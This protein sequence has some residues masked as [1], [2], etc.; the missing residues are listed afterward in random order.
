MVA[1]GEDGVGVG[2][3]VDDFDLERLYFIWPN[4]NGATNNPAQI[5]IMTRVM[6]R[7][8]CDLIMKSKAIL[9]RHSRSENNKICAR[10]FSIHVGH[11]FWPA[12]F[13]K[14]HN[15]KRSDREKNDIQHRRVI[16]SDRS[17]DNPGRMLFR[18]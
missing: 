1:A 15:Q 11:H 3:G 9:L 13:K 5:I 6:I 8:R 14:A 7:R 18:D 4:P 17:L 10:G 16:E 2:V 12:G